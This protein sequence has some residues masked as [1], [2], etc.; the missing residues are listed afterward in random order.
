MRRKER[1]KEILELIR[2]EW[3]KNPDLRLGQLLIGHFGFPSK[4]IYY[5]E[6]DLFKVKVF[7]KK[8]FEDY[9]ELSREDLKA[10]IQKLKLNARYN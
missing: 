5:V 9:G 8:P 2:I 3:E 1:I 4:D 6:D 7:E 10:E